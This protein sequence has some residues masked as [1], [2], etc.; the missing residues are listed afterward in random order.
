M[1]FAQTTCEFEHRLCGLRKPLVS[2]R[3]V[4]DI[5]ANHLWVWASFMRFAQTSCALWHRLCGLCKPL[6]RLSIV[7]EVCA[8]FL[9]T[10]ASFMRFVQTSCEVRASFKRFAQTSWEFACTSFKRFAQTFFALVL[11]LWVFLQTSCA[12]TQSLR[13]LR[14]LFGSVRIVMRFAQTSCSWRIVNEVCANLL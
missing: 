13:G 10:W 11:R 2:L 14:K 6:V 3:I 12:L 1:R 7:N 8:N 9:C 5:C 4:Y